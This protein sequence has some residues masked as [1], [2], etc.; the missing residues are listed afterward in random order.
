MN[1]KLL[2]EEQIEKGLFLKFNEKAILRTDSKSQME[3]LSSGVNNGI[4]TP[5][6]A[7][8]K[9]DLPSLE[10]GDQLIVN[11]NYIPITKVGTQYEKG[12]EVDAKN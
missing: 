10:G 11:G 12:G 3:C 9:L 6:E 4:Y 7:R 8:E 5:N 1:F 2:N